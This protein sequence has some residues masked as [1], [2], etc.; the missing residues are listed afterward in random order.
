MTE[1]KLCALAMTGMALVACAPD[2]PPAE[3]AAG[4]PDSNGGAGMQIHPEIWPGA[5]D[6]APLPAY[7]Q[8]IAALLERMTVEEKVGQIVQADIGSVTPEEVKQYNLGS[9]LNG[10]NSAPGGDNRAAA[11]EWL[12]LADEFWLASTDTTDGGVGIPAMWGTDAVHGHSNIVGATLFP[13]NIGL[14]AARNPDLLREIGRVTARE[15]LVT[16]HDWTF[17]PTVAVARDDRWGRTYESYSE[18]PSIVAQY[19]G[20][21]VEGIQGPRDSDDFLGDGKLIATAKHFVG[22]GGTVN[23]VDQGDNVASEEDLRDIHAAGYP[24]AIASGVQV[25]M[26]SYNSWHGRKLH[27]HRE[28]LTDVLVE[29]M[30]FDGF[31]VGDWNGHGQ[32]KGCSNESCPKAVNAGLDMF[33]APDSWRGVY[34]NTL[35]QVQA[36]EISMQRLDQAVARILRVKFRAGI[37]TAGLPSERQL[38]GRFDLLGS[39]EHRAVARQA[40]RESL[41]LLKNNDSLLPL[42]PAS[43][44]LVTGPGA[45]D[46]GMQSGGWTLSWQGTGNSNEHFPNGDSIYAAINTAVTAAGGSAELSA[47]GEYSARPDVAVVVYGETPY[48]EFQ[49]DKTH[50]DFDDDE[51]LAI[52]S[53]LRAD[54]IPTVSVFLS[55]RPLWVNPELNASDAFVAAWLPGSEGAGIAD[56]LLA[57]GDGGTGFDFRGKLSFSWPADP[58]GEPLNVGDDDYNPLFPFGYGLSYDAPADVGI[59]DESSSM[60]PARPNANAETVVEFGQAQ[61]PWALALDSGIEAVRA[62]RF[63]QED[64]LVLRW[65][66]SGKARFSGAAQ[67]FVRQTNA[68]MALEVTYRLTQKPAGPVAIGVGCG[69]DC[70]ARI[71]IGAALANAP[72][73]TWLTTRTTLSCFAERGANLQAI[74]DVLEI[75]GSENLELAVYSARIVQNPGDANCDF[76]TVDGN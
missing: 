50:L 68:D 8:E 51:P 73:A 53:K 16:G 11:L 74:T 14:G 10:G 54:G 15:M 48:A 12:A 30:G 37:M 76:S 7:E 45:D 75:D 62:D 32:I 65:S 1:Y 57:A 67:D 47:A 17:A 24:Q 9:V 49:G 18:D 23:G 56:V 3:D 35:R 40:V 21:I 26:A 6:L 4:A 39:P 28:L 19:A 42:S 66:E 46:I 13:H 29:R 69:N 63:A 44:V 58:E 20:A 61:Q 70:G 59:L 64:V 60:A 52:L 34:S 71:D 31:V 38:A 22:D 43:R 36:G 72:E 33:M 5:P 55:G 41:V 25:V 27:G 2:S